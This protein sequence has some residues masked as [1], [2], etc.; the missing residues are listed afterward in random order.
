MENIGVAVAIIIDNKA[1]NVDGIIMK[2]DGTGNAIRI[3]SMLISKKDGEEL[4]ELMRSS[5]DEELEQVAVIADFVMN[6][7]TD[8]VQFDFIYTSSSDKALD[9][10]SDFADIDTHFGDILEMTPHFVLWKC[11]NC[12]DSVLSKDCYGGGKYCAYESGNEKE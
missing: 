8:K 11:P 9:F 12:D 3:P 1:E 4:L 2:D 10:L 7:A 6:K 5:T